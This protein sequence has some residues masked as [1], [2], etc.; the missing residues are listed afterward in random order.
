MFCP[1]FLKFELCIATSIL[2][3]L[4]PIQCTLYQCST[5]VHGNIGVYY[6]HFFTSSFPFSWRE[7]CGTPYN[8]TSSVSHIPRLQIMSN[9]LLL[10]RYDLKQN[11]VERGPERNLAM[12]ECSREFGLTID[13]VWTINMSTG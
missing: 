12:E 1:C 10:W 6:I 9:H 7:Y 2:V 11:Q 8:A 3:H 4:C 13:H 5:D